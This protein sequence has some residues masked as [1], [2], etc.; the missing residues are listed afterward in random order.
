MG[1]LLVFFGGGAM[2]G[3]TRTSL[4]SL[5]VIAVLLFSAIGPTIVYADDGAPPDTSTAD[6]TGGSDSSEC[7]SDEDAEDSADSECSSDEVAEDSGGNEAGSDGE[8][9]DTSAG[10]GESSDADPAAELPET[11]DSESAPDGAATDATGGSDSA[12]GASEPQPAEDA[13]P[14]VE[15]AAPPADPNLLAE[16]PD[17]TSVTVLNADGQA[18]PL[19]TQDAVNAIASTTD[20]IW[21]PLGQPPIPSQNGCTPPF[22][23]FTDLL[24]YLSG[25]AAVQVAGT[26]YVEQGAYAGGESVIDFNAYNLSNISGFDLTV[27]GG[28]DTTPNPVDPATAGTSDFTVPIL[29]GSSTTPWGGSLTINNIQILNPQNTGLTLYSQN[30]ISLSNVTVD[31]SATGDGAVLNARADVT[32]NNSHFLRNTAGARITAGNNVAIASSEFSNP[33]NQRRQVTGLEITSGGSVSLFSVLA[34]G[35]RRVGTDISA[36]GRV[37]IGSSEFSETNGLNGGVFY[38]Y[39]LRVVTPDEIELLGVIANN[40]FLWGADL[41][42]GG[43]V[44]IGDSIFNANST[45]SPTFIDDTGLLVTSGSNVDLNNVT[46]DGNRL[47]GAT[48][49]AVGAVNIANSSF[50]NNRG[51]TTIGGTNTFHGLGLSVVSSSNV[52]LNAVTASGNGLTGAYLE[53]GIG[54]ILVKAS[55][56][57]NNDTGSAADVLGTGLTMVSAGNADIANSTLDNNQTYG[58]SIQAAGHSFLDLVTATNNGTDG[59]QVE[60]SCAHLNGGMYTDNGQYGLNLTTSALDLAVMPTFA[61]NAAGD[62]FPATPP[63]CPPLFPFTGTNPGTVS[64]QG[65]QS[66]AASLQ[67]SVSSS[68][69]GASTA[70]LFDTSLNSLVYGIT[71]EV[72]SN[73]VVTSI[74]AGQYIYVYTIYDVDAEPSLDNLQIILL[75]PAPLTGVA[76]VGP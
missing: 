40:N 33:F 20:P 34:I 64:N 60:V 67:Q 75:S 72:I 45:G 10:E 11:S 17:N 48:I 58:A 46:A 32:I 15:E 22:T 50:S 66:N 1:F 41:D 2:S 31:N 21:C 57:S 55:S 19:A 74:F 23:S 42:A 62:I 36:V 35:N 70:S 65:T 4:L 68:G 53:S 49:D 29:I 28:W 14:V 16:L 69:D 54:G 27:Q 25:N 26:I 59:V 30:S 47:I 3:K 61:N 18:E 44:A 43:R 56:F 7:S 12:E 38:G 8:A 52:S 76:R 37:T 6:T 39:G 24:N 51:V 71:R 73:G 63:T 13:A 5:A 9:T